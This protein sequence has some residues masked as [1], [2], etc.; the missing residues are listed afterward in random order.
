MVRWSDASSSLGSVNASMPLR[1]G[2]GL[3]LGGQAE[4]VQWRDT[5]KGHSRDVC[6]VKVECGTSLLQWHPLTP[7]DALSLSIS[8]HTSSVTERRAY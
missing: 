2:S 1:T 8:L 4:G 5:M 3:G 7:S 6:H